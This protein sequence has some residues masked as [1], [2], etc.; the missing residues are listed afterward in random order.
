MSIRRISKA[1]LE[2]PSSDGKPMAETGIHPEAMATLLLT[3]SLHYEDRKDVYV[4]SNNLIYYEKGNLDARF[5]PDVYVVFGIEKKS[6]RVFKTW[7]EKHA[8]AIVFEASSRSTWLEDVG[9]KKA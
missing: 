1:D 9:N 5:S 8:P 2:Y 7:E 3:L 4:A 6:R